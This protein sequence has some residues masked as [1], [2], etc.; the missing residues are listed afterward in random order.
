MHYI[1]S[2]RSIVFVVLLGIAL[3]AILAVVSVTL[4]AADI[5]FS[6]ALMIILDHLPIIGQKIDITGYPKMHGPIVM[7]LRLPRIILSI[8]VGSLLAGAGTV[9]QSVFRNPMADPFILGI[10]AGAAVGAALAMIVK[11]DIANLGL[12][13][14]AVSAF[15]GALLTTFIVYKIATNG[16]KTSLLSLILTGI[17][18]SYLLSALLS[19]L[20]TFNREELERIVFWMYG[21]FAV[22]SW[23]EVAVVTPIFIITVILLLFKGRVLNVMTMGDDV[24]TS[25]GVNVKRERLILL[26]ISSIATAAAVSVSGIIGF[27]GLVIPHVVRLINGPDNRALLPFSMVLGGIFLLICDA[28]SRVALPPMEIPIGIITSLLGAPYFIYLI[29]KNRKRKIQ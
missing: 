6:A 29:V 9:Y 24:A 27:V 20:I 14:V 21:S 5:S 8:F 23:N 3:L 19:I 17:A 2:K 11:F 13:S 10:S 16:R 7:N 1:K 15:I 4:G 12:G 25:L 26:F 22:S 28:I 18:I